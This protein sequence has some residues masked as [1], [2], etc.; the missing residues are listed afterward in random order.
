MR[1][2]VTALLTASGLAAALPLGS[3]S[4]AMAQASGDEP[5]SQCL[6]IAQALPRVMFA[7]ASASPLAV[8]GDVTISFAGHSTYRIETPAG[9]TIATDFSGVYG[10]T[11]TP[12]V[13]TMNRAHS[14]HFTLNPDPA[15]EHV[16]PGWDSGN[17]EGADHDT[18]I[19]D[20]Y[21]RNVTT[22][23]RRWDTTALTANQNSIFIFEVA[24]LCI[25]HLGHLHHRLTD[26]HFAQIGRLD[27]V[28][29]PVDGG[30]T[31]AHTGM[32]EITT[33]LRSSIVLP[34]HLR[35]NSIDRFIALMGTDWA[36]DFLDGDAI[37]VNVRDL[38]ERP[39][40]IVPASLA[41][42]G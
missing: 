1:R 35:G 42:R 24:G 14:T 6:A 27:I 2:L 11:P 37:T 26:D 9:V 17:P 22:D 39:T 23:I 40:I 28:M 25:G 32:A 38:P 4:S 18:V 34:M 21:V 29:V 36:V 3:A 20:V 33:R 13:V 10:H 30:L 5:V 15:I 8:D 41:R 12:R 16:F 7:S 19:D 31:M